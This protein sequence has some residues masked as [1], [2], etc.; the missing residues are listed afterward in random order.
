MSFLPHC[1]GKGIHVHFCAA[2]GKAVVVYNAASAKKRPNTQYHLIYI[3][4]FYHVIIRTGHKAYALIVKGILAGLLDGLPQGEAVL[5]HAGLS[6]E[7]GAACFVDLV[8]AVQDL[9][10]GLSETELAENSR[11][12]SAKL[13]VFEAY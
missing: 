7:R 4:R 11:S 2:D 9:A 3:N 6:G 10:G 8:V 13:R 1:D 12:K 5:G